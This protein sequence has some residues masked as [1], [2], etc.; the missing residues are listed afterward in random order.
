[1]TTPTT[2]ESPA[3]VSRAEERRSARIRDYASVVTP[4]GIAVSASGRIAYVRTESNPG[5]DT[6]EHSIWLASPQ[7]QLTV[8][9][10]DTS[11]AWHPVSTLLVFVRPDSSGTPQL[12]KVDAGGGPAVQMTTAEQLPLGAGAPV[13]SP[14]GARIAFSAPVD[15]TAAG[16][17]HLLV[18][19]RL[20][21]KVD[22]SGVRGSVRA[23]L[24][25]FDLAA[26]SLRQLTDGDWDASHPAYSPDGTELAF[27]AAMDGDADLT[28][29]SS[30]WTVSLTDLAAAP[31]MLGHARGI[32]G[33]LA[34]TP[35][36]DAVVAVGWHTPIIHNSELLVLHRDQRM[37][38]R[39]LTSELDRNV[40]PGGTGYPGGA[41]SFTADGN[42]VFCVRNHGSTELHKVDF[43]SG[44]VSPLLIGEQTVVSGL[45]LVS[46]RAVVALATATS[47][48]EVAVIDLE[49]RAVE[50]VTELNTE[51]TTSVAF[52][53]ATERWFDISDGTRVQGWIL[54][55][56]NLTGTGPL[57]LDVH[58]GPHNAWTGTPTLMHAY[59]AELVALGYTVLMINPRGSDGYGNDFFDGVRDGWGEADRADLLEPVET[60]VAEGVADP[61]QLVLTGYSYGGFMT[62]ALTSV[63]DRF[64]VA[65]AG[66]LVCDIANTA[67]PSDEGILLQ[68]IEFDPQS[69]RVQE[70]SPLARVS[71]VTTPTLI[72]HGGSDVRCP[73]NQAEQWF[74]GLRLT[75]TPTELVVFPDASHAFVLTGRPS[76]RL[77][78]STRLVDWIER[79]LSPTPALTTVDPDYWQYRLDTL[80]AKYGVPGASLGILTTTRS[81]FD[82]TVVT[83][84]VVSTRTGVAATP[85]TL[86]QMGSISK[87]W[88]A[89]LIMQLVEEGL[90]D[91]DA[92]VRNILPDFAVDDAVA[93]ATV[94]T[95]QLLTHTSGID[96]DVF[97]DG[98]RGDDCVERYVAALKS[99][100][101]LFAPGTDWSYCN[102]GFVIAGRIIEVLRG[103]SWDAVLRERIIEPL[104]LAKTTTLP[105]ET[106]LHRAAVGHVGGGDNLAQTPQFLI[107]RSMGPAGLINSTAE[108][109]LL[110]AQDSMRDDPILL[111]R[112]THLAML[113][114]R[115]QIGDVS[116]AD[117][118]GTTWLLHNWDGVLAHGHNGG[119]LG[120]QS[121]LRVVPSCGIAVVLMANGGAMDAL[122]GDLLAEVI[123]SI[124]GVAVTPAFSPGDPHTRTTSS[125]EELDALCGLYRDA[126]ADFVL[127]RTGGS[128]TARRTDHID[129]SINAES[130]ESISLS[131]I[132]VHPGVFATQL[133]Q[134]AGW[135]RITFSD[136]GSTQ[137]LHV[138]SRA[139]PR[140]NNR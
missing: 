139:Y 35:A 129:P 128:L 58:G 67:G 137:L 138:G 10:A 18:A 73:V 100:V 95:R 13:F 115:R 116:S 117:I 15:R 11:P 52:P 93:T 30:A 72:L 1:M 79:H 36:G 60:L 4:T 20:N 41:P 91:L 88:T 101:Q 110:F 131:L 12:W 7:L 31:R 38:D 42:I 49:T 124:G 113:E 68:T 78:Y 84:G 86:F 29:A 102:T 122:S 97:I 123:G 107:P 66:G 96:G 6:N 8:G 126:A 87:V 118:M 28:R 83:S 69:S 14:D 21:Y 109:L 125:P 27:T 47:F 17:S 48:G 89:T 119:T 71:Q 135:I 53:V 85:D 16:S 120:Q 127:E 81:G 99:T 70:L 61:K 114:E 94:T 34:W 2:L 82:R 98:G 50:I 121:F 57:V 5:A 44:S 63:T 140:V 22:G 23:H 62:C 90:L 136:T 39:S 33:P 134:S 45:A 65:V 3:A 40:M 24:F 80:S 54:R 92:P 104:G 106:A 76:H 51:L 9:P 56:P 59:H 74:G 37:E 43:G 64:A 26:G 111:Q 19:K 112:S 132:E 108:D 75:G 55:D 103:K 32:A 25:E 105:E 133:P 130:A 77:G 46:G